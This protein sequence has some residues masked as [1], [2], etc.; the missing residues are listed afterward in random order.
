MPVIATKSG[1]TRYFDNAQWDAMDGSHNGWTLVSRVDVEKP[2]AR[3]PFAEITPPRVLPAEPLLAVQGTSPIVVETYGGIATVSIAPAEVDGYVLT[4]NDSGGYWEAKAPAGGTV[5]SVA[6]AMSTDVFDISGSPVTGSGT[7]TVTLD[8]QTANTVWAGPTTG[9]ATT[10]TFRALVLADLPAGYDT[11]QTITL[12][13]DVTGSGTTAITTS[14]AA[15]TVGP[16]ELIDTAVTPGSYTNANITVDAQGRITAASNGT[17]GGPGSGT[18]NR[19]AYWATGTTLGAD[20]DF[21]FN[22]SNVGIGTTTITDRLNVSGNTR[23]YDGQHKFGR[24]SGTIPTAYATVQ[25]EGKASSIS[26]PSTPSED[27]VLILRGRSSG[28]TQY[29]QSLHFGIDTNSNY[30]TFIQARDHADYTSYYNMRLN[31]RGG[32]VSVG[33]QTSTTNTAHVTIYTSSYTSSSGA[34]SYLLNLEGSEGAARLGFSTGNDLVHSSQW[35]DGVNLIMRTSNLR[36]ESFATIRWSIGT[37]ETADKMVLAAN[38]AGRL[39]VGFASTSGLH[40]TLQS[41]GSFAAG[42]L[43]TVG[44]PTFDETKHVVV[45]TGSSNVTWI[46]PSASTCTGRIYVLHHANSTG[47]ITLSS[48]ITKGGGGNFNTLT[49]GEWAFIVAGSA[50]WRGYKLT[51]A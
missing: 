2:E 7:I 5:T 37:S 20:D 50:S 26:L 49:G 23:F 25:I 15:D 6:L 16:T 11:N 4:W 10:P 21:V 43:E 51:S 27:S 34:G 30:G 47:T 13:G 9:G 39:G 19:V 24:Y 32:K 28:G 29:A 18:A 40:S 48:S 3:R 33:R 14:I 35:Y 22:G 45:Y 36:S 46:L 42:F 12:S 8:N 17:G 44:A 38:G 41:G 31:P 1:L